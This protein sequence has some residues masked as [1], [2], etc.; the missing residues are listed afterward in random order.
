MSHPVFDVHPTTRIASLPGWVSPVSHYQVSASGVATIGKID[1]NIENYYFAEGVRGY[2]YYNFLKP[3]QMTELKI[4]GKT[5]MIDA[6]EYV[7]M[8]QSFAE[9]STGTVLVAGLGLGIVLNYLVRNPKVTNIIV[10]ELEQDVMDLIM[11]LLP[12]DDRLH[13]VH[14]D[15]YEFLKAP[16]CTIDTVIWDLAVINNLEQIN[17]VEMFRS[18]DDCIRCL[19]KQVKVFRH[20]LDRDAIGEEF[21]KTDEFKAARRAMGYIYG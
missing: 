19:G 13:I 4:R 2:L 16:T 6:P 7:W 21:A 10:M 15:F 11:P 18:K 14:G 17:A 3:A 9:Q 12:K 20:G 5:W 1:I 8:L